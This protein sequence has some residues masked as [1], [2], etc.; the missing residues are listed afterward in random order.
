M[1]SKGKLVTLVLTGIL[2]LTSTFVSSGCFPKRD[3]WNKPLKET[4]TPKWKN[5]KLLTPIDYSK[6]VIAKTENSNYNSPE[7]SL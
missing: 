3:D 2:G 7:Y 1:A 5:E 4:P 6:V